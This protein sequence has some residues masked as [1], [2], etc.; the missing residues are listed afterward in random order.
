MG[1]KCSNYRSMIANLED[2]FIGSPVNSE[3]LERGVDE[4][5]AEQPQADANPLDPLQS[6][7]YPVSTLWVFDQSKRLEEQQSYYLDHPKMGMLVTIKPHEVE[8]TN[9]LEEADLE[10]DLESGFRARIEAP[11]P[12]KRKPLGRNLCRW[13]CI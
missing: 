12:I 9:P 13:R 11:F 6:V 7:E 2:F 8:I 4:L 5:E 10:T 3:A 1:R